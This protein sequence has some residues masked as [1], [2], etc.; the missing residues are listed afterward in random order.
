MNIK[1]R[2]ILL[3]IGVLLILFSIMTNPSKSDYLD[4]ATV[5]VKEHEGL[6]TGIIAGPMLK[7]ST[8]KTNFFIFTIY[9]TTLEEKG[10]PDYKAIGILN[11]FYWLKSPYDNKKE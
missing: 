2:P 10:S 8:T 4:W 9:N 11:N 5:E 7:V 3:T 1:L 6:I